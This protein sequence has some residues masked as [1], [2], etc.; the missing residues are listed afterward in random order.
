LEYAPYWYNLTETEL[1]THNRT[2]S[3]GTNN[4]DN[5]GQVRLFFNDG[6]TTYKTFEECSEKLMESSDQST[7]SEAKAQQ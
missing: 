6:F 7:S 5:S 1:N 2:K 4:A 3:S